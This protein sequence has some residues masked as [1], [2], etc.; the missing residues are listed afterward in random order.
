MSNLYT[1]QSKNVTK[2]WVLMTIFFVVIIGLGWFVSYYYGNP[3]ILYIFVLFSIVMN[4]ASYWYSDKIVL[5]MTR[6]KEAKREE[7]FDLY[8]TVENLA[9]TA[10]LPKP[11]VYVIEDSA[12]NAFPPARDQ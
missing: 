5:K 12:P 10:G 7:Y 3:N 1:N 9:I 11:K 4:I 6:A 8:T 2:T